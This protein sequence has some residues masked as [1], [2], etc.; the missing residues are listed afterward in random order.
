VTRR[1]RG[2][3]IVEQLLKTQAR[4]KAL[5]AKADKLLDKLLEVLEVGAEIDLGDGRVARLVD[6]FADR[7]VCWRSSSFNRFKVE[8]EERV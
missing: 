1:K 2:A 4:G 3:R 6:Q 7:R 8:V 5:Y